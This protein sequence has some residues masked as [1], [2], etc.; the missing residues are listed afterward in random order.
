MKDRIAIKVFRVCTALAA[1]VAVWCFI[2][3]VLGGNSLYWLIVGCANAA[4]A[5]VVGLM[6]VRGSKNLK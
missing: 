4:C 1:F 6:A 5:S 2:L 3:S